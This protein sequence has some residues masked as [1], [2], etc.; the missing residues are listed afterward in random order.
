MITGA[1]AAGMPAAWVASDEAYGDSRA[2]L[3]R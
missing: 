3:E 2:F 1:V